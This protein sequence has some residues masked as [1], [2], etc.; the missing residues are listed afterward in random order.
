MLVQ[1]INAAFGC[2]IRGWSM[3]LVFAMASALAVLAEF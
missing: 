1:C 2:H 3:A